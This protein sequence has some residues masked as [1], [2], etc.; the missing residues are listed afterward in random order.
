MSSYTGFKN[1]EQL[2]AKAGGP[3]KLLRSSQVGAYVFPVVPPEYTNYGDEQYA[4]RHGCA[5]LELSYHQTDLYVYGPGALP[6][7][8]RV[9][10]NNFRKFPPKRAKQLVACS[11]DGYLIADGMC[12]HLEQDYFRIAGSPLISDWVQYNAG[13]GKYDVELHRDETV[14]FRPG[15]PEIYIFQVQGPLALEMMRDVTEGTLPEIGFFHIGDIKIKGRN[16]RALRH[17]MAGEHGF[18]LFGPWSEQQIVRDAIYQA[19]AKYDMKKVGGLAYP[20]TAVESAWLALPLPAV[21]HSEATKPYREWLSPMHIESQ[22]SLGGSFYSENVM[23]YYV[24]AYGMGYERFIDF[25][26]DFIGR[27]ALKER[28]K[29]PRRKKVTLVWNSD[30]VTEVIRASLFSSDHPAKRIH[31][32]LAAHATFHYDQVLRGG[33]HTGTSH[34][35]A[36]TKNVHAMLSVAIVNEEDSV[37][38]TPVTVLWGETN[39][40]RPNIEKHEVREIR[41]TVAQAPYFEKVIKKD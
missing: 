21:Y 3:V 37:P 14:S 19:G 18:E 20:M 28:G 17:G 5:F 1:L 29:Q 33:K 16:V 40:M 11:P 15:D 35:A 12:F 38:G 13:N 31:L 24:D 6:L 34:F 4:W 39:P 30:D 25:E 41:A 26:H 10:I 27:E 36:Y 7:L 9:G 23:D 8:S 22:A 32:P 2:I